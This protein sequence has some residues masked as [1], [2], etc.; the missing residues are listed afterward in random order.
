[1]ALL[2]SLRSPC[3]LCIRPIIALHKT[4]SVNNI[5]CRRSSPSSSSV[6]NASSK[7]KQTNISTTPSYSYSIKESSDVITLRNR[8]KIIP[9]GQGIVHVRLS[10]PDK[11]NSL[12]LDMFDA[13][14]EAAARLRDDVDLKKNLRVV[15]F[16]GEGKA[17]CT[18]LD[19]KSVALSGPS[20]SLRRLLERPSPFGGEGEGPKGNLAQ[21]V[22]YLWRSLPVPVITVIH[23]M[24]Y[25]G[26]LQIALGGDIRLS[27]FDCKISIMESRWGLIPDMGIS[28]TLREL[29]RMDVAKE[30]T[31]TGRIINGK[32]AERIGLVTRCVEDPMKEAMKVA[33]EIV[34]RSPDSVAATKELFQSTWVADE[35]SCLNIETDLQRKLIG[36]R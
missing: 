13:I 33:M 22:C 31:M 32:E 20:A 16:S 28:I 2:R 26:G 3:S 24:C 29:V 6:E 21:D 10:R 7:S 27:T 11:L 15:I 23:G 1:M 5:I 17:F 9:L 8:V 30:L 36:E 35:E 19:A 4:E 12:D 14:A 25:G 18:G 34:E